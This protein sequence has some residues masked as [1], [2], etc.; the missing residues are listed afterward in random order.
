MSDIEDVGGQPF[1]KDAQDVTQLPDFLPEMRGRVYTQSAHITALR[2]QHK[3]ARF[4]SFEIHSDEPPWLGG[5]EAHPQ[6]LTYLA[7]AV[8]F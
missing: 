6:P 1:G 2:K 7:A 8:G 4:R 5:E 3:V